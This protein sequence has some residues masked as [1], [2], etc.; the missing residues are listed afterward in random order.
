MKI[1]LIIF[2]C[3]LVSFL[4]VSLCSTPKRKDEGT[5]AA[6]ICQNRGH[7]SPINRRLA[8]EANVS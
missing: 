5:L 1:K 2:I 4:C 7:V 3:L 6:G 8:R